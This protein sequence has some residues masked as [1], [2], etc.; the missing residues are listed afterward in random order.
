[1]TEESG[2]TFNGVPAGYFYTDGASSLSH[3][4]NSCVVIAVFPSQ[5]YKLVNDIGLSYYGD[6]FEPIDTFY[7]L[8]DG[9]NHYVNYSGIEETTQGSYKKEGVRG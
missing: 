3:T 4:A 5:C 1:M 8:L 6:L 2:Y 9:N 7:G